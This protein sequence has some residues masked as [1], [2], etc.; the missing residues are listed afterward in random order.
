M[1]QG[2]S[3]LLGGSWRSG[4]FQTQRV[5]IWGFPKIRGTLLEIP[6]IR[7]VVFWGLY[8]GPRIL[9]NYH[10]GTARTKYVTYRELNTLCYHRSW[11][12]FLRALSKAN[13][14]I[15]EPSCMPY[16]PNPRSPGTH[17][18]GSH[19]RGSRSLCSDL[20]TCTRYI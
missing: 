9:G 4:K 1:A 10:I 15:Q 19:A 7:T 12:P 2:C 17:I 18:L 6:I 14:R 8:W 3:R 16:I 20:G 11:R 13:K 5:T